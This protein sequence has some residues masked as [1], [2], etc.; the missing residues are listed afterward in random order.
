MD[1]LLLFCLLF[2][3]SLCSSPIRTSRRSKHGEDCISDPACEE[4]LFCKINRC[5]TFYE[6]KNLKKL[7]LFEKNICDDIK[8]KCKSDKICINHR[9][10]DKSTQIETPKIRSENQNDVHLIFGG[11][12]FLNKKP[13]ESGLKADGSCNYDHLFTHIEKDIKNA[14]L[15]I[16]DQET[17]FYFDE[18]KKKSKKVLTLTPKEL[19]DSISKAGFKVV[20]H[21]TPFAYLRKENGIIDTLNFWK[22]KHPDVHPLGISSSL[23]ESEKDYFIFRKNNIKIGII[24]FNSFKIKSIPKK[25]QFMIN[26]I[27]TKKIEDCVQKL[28][29]ETD[30]VI[31]CMNWGEKKSSLPS[32]RQIY[33]AKILASYGVDLIIGNHP[34]FIQP[35]SFVQA[36]NGKRT[37]VFFSLG[38]LIGDNKN[39]FSTLSALADIVISKDKDKAYISSYSLIPII[40]HKDE[41]G[42]YS[43]YKLSEYNENLGKQVNKKFSLEK[44]RKMCYQRIGAFSYCD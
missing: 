22:T 1:I 18:D 26:T 42:E 41:S 7:G 13:Y 28:K 27:T 43:A 11:G 35:V 5:M 19:G 36:K 6:T 37:L 20:L 15:S 33:I 4:G 31:V 24:N 34:N 44:I 2:C 40:N 30:F 39:I 9:C 29:E 10:V 25:N 38:L 23:E 17:V 12:I 3:F 32:K 14:D 8:K 16:V 21:A